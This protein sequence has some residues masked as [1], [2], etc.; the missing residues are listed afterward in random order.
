MYNKTTIAQLGMCKVK[1]KHNKKPKT[2]NYFVDPGNGQALLGMPD[3]DILDV[4]TINFARI[5]I[6]TQNEQIYNKVEDEQHCNNK[7]QEAGKPGKCNVNATSIQNSD[8]SSNPAV[9]DNDNSKI[10]YFL[11]GSRQVAD[12]RASAEIIQNYIEFNDILPG[13]R[14]RQS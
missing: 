9:M 10:K 5:D 6:Q 3:I 12:K 8:N 2:C 11:P 14:C 4:L 7:M 13:I 1:C